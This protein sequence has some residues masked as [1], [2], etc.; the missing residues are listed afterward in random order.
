ML[1]V[2][3]Y[4]QYSL[5]AIIAILLINRKFTLLHAYAFFIPFFGIDF[6]IGVRMTISQIV[7]L[8]LNIGLILGVKTKIG[9]ASKGWNTW[10]IIFLLY[11]FIVS[12]FL[13]NYEI[14]FIQTNNPGFLRNEGRYI[15]QIINF[16][17]WFS[18]FGVAYGYIKSLSKI[19]ELIK[20]FLYGILVL[21]ILGFIQ[22]LVFIVSGIDIMPLGERTAGSFNYFGVQM[23]RVCSLAGEPKSFGMYLAIGIVVLKVFDQIGI[24]IINHS[25][26]IS[27]FFVINLIFTL[28]TSGF[29][30]LAILW[31]V[32][33]LILRFYGISPK[34]SSAS[35]IS[36]LFLIT[37]LLFF[38]EPLEN[39]LNDRIMERDITNEDFDVTVK[40]FLLD[41]PEWLTFGSGLGNIHN[42][43]QEYI[44]EENLFY[45]ENNISVAKSGYLR[46][47]S[48]TGFVGFLFFLI[49]NLSII[50]PMFNKYNLQRSKEYLLLGLLATLGLLCFLARGGYL[51]E[52]FLFFLSI[53][54][55]IQKKKA[56]LS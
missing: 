3:Y 45:M 15:S 37:A 29:I 41:N 19:Y 22:Q 44:P 54:Y 2:R 28:S 30:L 39:I 17:L 27:Y 4:I 26:Y 7:L 11:S 49:F 12:I 21:A 53:A 5:I 23:I 10:V 46:I 32:S 18:I 42:L 43:T 1:E 25:K 16:S 56:I 13:S 24:K 40:N 14:D 6:D 51:I 55:V 36:A 38:S 47:I 34:I 31:V 9:I 52:A 33:E 35:F 8:L 48:E 20:F 50:F